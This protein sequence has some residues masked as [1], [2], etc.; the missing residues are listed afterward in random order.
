MTI[1]RD[2][3]G[4]TWPD[5]EY[6]SLPCPS[7]DARLILDETSFRRKASRHNIELVNVTSDD[8]AIARFSAMFVCGHAKCGEI[9]WVSGDCSYAYAYG[10]DGETITEQTL[11]P[12]SLY[13]GSPVIST[14][15]DVSEEIQ[16][17]LN[18]SYQL[19][20]S[21]YDACAIKLRVALERILA[22]EGF[23]ATGSKGSFVS[24]HDRILRWEALTSETSI[25]QSLT[26]IKW[27]G[28]EASHEGRLSLTNV[29]DAYAL[30]ERLLQQL[31][32]LDT[33]HIDALAERINKTK[34]RST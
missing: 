32:P 10:P 6:P 26:A 34:G 3:W 20:W 13:P 14:P 1:D 33:T 11:H 30:L 16:S 2:I 23:P 24:L 9:V 27:L 12:K 17:A 25:A 7:C 29:L 4:A 21:D 15:D 8:E 31:F 28:N 19:L 22:G 5:G 18:V